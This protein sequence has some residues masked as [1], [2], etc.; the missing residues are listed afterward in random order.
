MTPE[1]EAEGY[2]R[3]FARNVQ[4]VRKKTGLQ[5]GDEILLKVSTNN[6]LQK[7]LEKHLDFLKERVNAKKIVFVEG[8]SSE[9]KHNFSIK[10][11]K[12]SI[13]LE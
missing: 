3:E 9:M 1:L 2:S 7:M 10:V 13:E 5:K 12:V 8:K 6:S 4:A 11:T